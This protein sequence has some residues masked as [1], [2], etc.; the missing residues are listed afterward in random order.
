MYPALMGNN[1][2]INQ[3][4]GAAINSADV[5]LDCGEFEV[6]VTTLTL[7]T[8]NDEEAANNVVEW[9]S[10]KFDIDLTPHVVNSRVER[11][12]SPPTQ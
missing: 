3:P 11:V 4:E 9:L 8:L 2:E 7:D 5:F 6:R 10:E 1:N 12:T